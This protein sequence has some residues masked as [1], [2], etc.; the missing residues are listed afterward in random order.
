MTVSQKITELR[1]A[2]KKRASRASFIQEMKDE[3]KKVSWTTKDELRLCGKI[4]IGAI[5]ALGIGI[6][7]VDLLIKLVL[8]GAG[9][10]V[11]LIGA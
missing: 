4:V 10:F 5:F 11:R 6:Y 8:D 7:T 2:K 3:L 1:V 9:Y